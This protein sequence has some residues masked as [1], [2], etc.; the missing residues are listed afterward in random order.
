MVGQIGE[1]VDRVVAGLLGVR[2]RDP[3][4]DL[5]RLAVAWPE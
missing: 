1:A 4:E 5:Q 2:D 3:R